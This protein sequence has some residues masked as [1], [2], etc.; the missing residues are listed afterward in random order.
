M[1]REPKTESAEFLDLN[2]GIFQ[3]SRFY[4]M[5]WCFYFDSNRNFSGFLGF[6]KAL[7]NLNGRDEIELSKSAQGISTLSAKFKTGVW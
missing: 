4:S 7:I 6:H 1:R 5:R 2:S 3:I